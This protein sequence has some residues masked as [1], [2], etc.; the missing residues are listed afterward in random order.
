[1]SND[2]P[3]DLLG[4]RDELMRQARL[5]P[6]PPYTLDEQLTFFCPQENLEGLELPVVR[7]FHEWISNDFQPSS[8]DERAI[9]LLLPCEM[10]K[11]Y[12]LSAEHRAVSGILAEEGFEPRARGD[13]PEELGMLA[14]PAELSNQPLFNEVRGLR[15]DRAVISEPF[16][17]VPYEAVYTWQG[18]P[19]PCA[20]YDDPGL[21][22]HR[23][24]GPLWRNDC[25]ATPTV[26]G[27]VWGDNEKRAYVEV[28]E[29]LS[30]LIGRTL[31][32]LAD[33]YDSI[34]AYVSHALTHRTFLA[35]DSE[36]ASAGIPRSR[37][38]DGTDLKLVGVN[39]RSPGLVEL[40][41]DA[42]E[43]DLIR[44][45]SGGVLPSEL[46]TGRK[47]LDLLRGKIRDA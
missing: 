24:I 25:T 10:E 29:R 7:K 16:G 26:D 41:P 6:T 22:E 45:L 37:Q 32:R 12:P 21:F 28:H 43:L 36:R 17:L 1:M 27:Y 40:V 5:K 3:N 11:P 23:G 34:L 20:R 8:G 42:S 46:L 19:S 38:I 31:I 18:E 9:L 4:D 35:S 44:S 39:D 15:I 30:V 2:P 33:R 14:S 13:W 47:S